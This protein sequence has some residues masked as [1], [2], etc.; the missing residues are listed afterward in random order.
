[1]RACD[2]SV[3]HGAA[4]VD[5][6][7]LFGGKVVE[8][9]GESSC[10]A[11][12]C[13]VWR[14]VVECGAELSGVPASVGV[15]R[16]GVSRDGVVAGTVWSAGTV[17]SAGTMLSAGTDRVSWEGSSQPGRGQPGRIESAG[18]ANSSNGNQLGR[19]ESAGTW[20]AGT[21]LVSWDGSSQ[22]GLCRHVG[23]SCRRLSEGCVKSTLL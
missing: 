8:C 7:V 17:L 22:P 12:G 11:Q 16:D 9:C 14:R 10:V 21:D 3:L 2:Q 6:Y 13:R 20:S 15:C 19:I 4:A 23:G 1:M 5:S 18:T